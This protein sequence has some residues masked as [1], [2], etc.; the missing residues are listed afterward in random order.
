MSLQTVFV[1]F[2]GRVRWE[3]PDWAVSIG[4]KLLNA[5]RYLTA[6]WRRAVVVVAGL[7][8]LVGFVYWYVNLPTPHYVAYT[9]ENPGLTEYDDKGIS[10]IKAMKV[11]FV[12]PAA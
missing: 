8:I 1:R 11:K 3:P 10:S 9:V 6:S 2:L 7:A 5:W 4:R 12:E